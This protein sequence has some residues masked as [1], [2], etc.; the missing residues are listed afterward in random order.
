MPNQPL[1][2]DEARA[3]ARLLSG[4]SY[5]VALTLEDGDTFASDTTAEFDCARPGASTF[6]DLEAHAVVSAELNGRP[7]PAEAFNGSRLQVEGLAEH[8]RLRVVG[9][10]AYGATGSGPHRFVHSVDCGSYLHS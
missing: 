2:R 4:V 8:N 6:V 5:A 1:T 10:C 9:R 3:R 7:I